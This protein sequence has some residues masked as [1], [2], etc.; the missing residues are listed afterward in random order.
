M[1]QMLSEVLHCS[2]FSDVLCS[3]AFAH[4]EDELCPADLQELNRLCLNL[5]TFL[6]SCCPLLIGLRWYHF[7]CF[8]CMTASD[9]LL[10]PHVVSTSLPPPPSFFFTPSFFV[11]HS[12]CSAHP[13]VVLATGTVWSCAR[14]GRVGTCCQNR[15]VL[16][17]VVPPRGCAVT[18]S[19]AL[20]LS[21]WQA[22]GER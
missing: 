4:A 20:P 13:A 19:A 12:V 18:F 3:V 1:N 21:G 16:N 17:M 14:A 22:L 10:H 6:Y 5:L 9:L 7:A 11:F 15:S 2:A 8:A